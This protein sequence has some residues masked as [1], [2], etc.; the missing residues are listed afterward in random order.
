MKN[1]PRDLLKQFIGICGL[2]SFFCLRQRHIHYKVQQ[3]LIHR[4]EGRRVADTESP[5]VRRL[6]LRMQI[7][8]SLETLDYSSIMT[9]YIYNS[10]GTLREG[11]IVVVLRAAGSALPP[12]CYIY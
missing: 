1:V 8:V 3:E 5:R 4:R 7:V 6:G 11:C 10:G 2:L 12:P 9:T